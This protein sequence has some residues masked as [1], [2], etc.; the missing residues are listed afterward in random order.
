MGELDVIIED[1]SG[2]EIARWSRSGHINSDWNKG[3]VSLPT[4]A[5]M[6]KLTGR[7]GSSYRSDIAL[8][9]F[10]IFH[11]LPGHVAF[12]AVAY[13]PTSNAVVIFDHVITNVGGGY[14][15]TT[16]VFT[17]PTPGLYVFSWTIETYG[18]RT[19]A[20]L[21]VNGV[22]QALSRADQASS[23]YDTTTSF[24][25]LK[26]SLDDE[27]KV[28]VT[29]GSAQA[30]HTMFSGWKINK[31]DDTAFFASLSRE[32]KGSA[33]VFDNETLDTDSAYS[34]SNGSF[35]APR[36]GLY[37]FMMS[38]I[39]YGL[40]NFNTKFVFSNG[41]SQPLLW[42]GSSGTLYDSSSYMSFG[43]LNAGD[44]VYVDAPTMTTHSVFAGWQLVDNSSAIKSNY[45]VFLAHLS[46]HSSRAPVI[47]DITHSGYHHGYSVS[48]GVFTAD[49]D[50]VYLL[51]YNIEA[52]SEIVI[53][54]LRVNGV[55]KFETRS[56]G[57][58]SGFDE[59]SAVTVLELSL[60]DQV[61]I[62]VE[63][64]R[65][66]SPESLFFGVLLIEK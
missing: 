49:R 45:P 40:S 25:V 44:Y 65:A 34:T 4:N 52:R 22:Q 64:G 2:S 54:T 18:Q 3:F 27:V 24:A 62:G 12:H 17:V 6:V 14:D 56:D 33:I 60:N 66:D 10:K 32:V 29:T 13:S 38:A 55:Q 30:M 53:T 63:N 43:W 28:K 50:G 61:S 8:D 59:T 15:N 9:D 42:V 16:G 11:C 36:S 51:L 35:V 21:L 57:R 46:S 1:K 19:E 23:Y 7:R 37:V 47:F 41:N 20:V 5:E 58:H 39:T 48:T 26:L 31:M